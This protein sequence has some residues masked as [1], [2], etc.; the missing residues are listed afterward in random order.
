MF[1]HSPI[2]AVLMSICCASVQA[3][4]AGGDHDTIRTVAEALTISKVEHMAGDGVAGH[5]DLG[6]KRFDEL[7]GSR[8]MY[9]PELDDKSGAISRMVMEDFSGGFSDPPST[10]LYDFRRAP[11]AVVPIS[12]LDID[13][14][15]WQPGTVLLHAGDK[16]HTFAN[17]LQVKKHENNGDRG[18]CV[19][20]NGGDGQGVGESMDRRLQRGRGDCFHID[21]R[22]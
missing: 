5:V 7:Y 1:G 10:S 22:P 2:L 19:R 9:Y 14:V 13:D 17:V 12:K 11:P 8:H 3:Q 18:L 15:R 21:D 16:W 4:T 6:G 20:R